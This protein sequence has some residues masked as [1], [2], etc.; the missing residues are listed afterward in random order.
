MSPLAMRLQELFSTNP[1]LFCTSFSQWSLAPVRH[2]PPVQPLN[3]S[4]V[5]LEATHHSSCLQDPPPWKQES[6]LMFLDSPH[7]HFSMLF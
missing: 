1:S 4:H 2:S 3:L 5:D 7:I 6:V